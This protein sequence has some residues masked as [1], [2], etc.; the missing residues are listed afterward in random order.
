[1]A[2]LATVA[3]AAPSLP[4]VMGLSGYHLGKTLA[5]VRK[6]SACGLEGLLV[7][8]PSYIRPSQ[9]GLAEWF[10]AIADASAVPLL[11]Y[12]IRAQHLEAESTPDSGQRVH[13]K[14]VPPTDKTPGSPQ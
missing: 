4:R 5:W 13:I 10:G 2:V 7:P 14:I 11:V 3:A 8:A 12:D 6:L 9:A 1:M